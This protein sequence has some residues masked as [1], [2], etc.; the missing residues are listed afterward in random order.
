[1]SEEFAPITAQGKVVASTIMMMGVLLIALPSLTISKSY[2]EVRARYELQLLTSSGGHG[3][4]DSLDGQ[5][6]DHSMLVRDQT[7][8]LMTIMEK[9]I[10]VLTM[11]QEETQK[12]LQL[13]TN[14]LDAL[15]EIQSSSLHK[16]HLLRPTIKKR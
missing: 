13:L 1:M 12:M 4:K 3:V 8:E 6:S 9:Q 16:Q 11:K 10:R 7:E 14:N 5:D 2:K 15:R